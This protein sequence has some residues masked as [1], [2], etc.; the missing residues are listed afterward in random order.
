MQERCAPFGSI[1]SRTLSAMTFFHE[2]AICCWP[3]SSTALVSRWEV[4]IFVVES[5][6]RIIFC[7]VRKYQVIPFSAIATLNFVIH[8]VVQCWSFCKMYQSGKE[9]P[10]V[11]FLWNARHS[12][13]HRLLEHVGSAQISTSDIPSTHRSCRMSS[14]FDTRHLLGFQIRC[15]V[16]TNN[17]G[18]RCHNVPPILHFTK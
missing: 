4:A 3:G 13:S 12:T 17:A 9:Y 14:N 7:A 18:V 8:G 1:V 16:P 6:F 15:D 2:R 10:P 5:V 11:D